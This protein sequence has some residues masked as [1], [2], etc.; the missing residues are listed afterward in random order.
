MFGY[1]TIYCGGFPKLRNEDD[2]F[3]PENVLDEYTQD[4]YVYVGMP[5]IT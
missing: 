1:S 3:I 5:V 4:M 2:M